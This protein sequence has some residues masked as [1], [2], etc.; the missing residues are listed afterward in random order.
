MHSL[1]APVKWIPLWSSLAFLLRSPRLLGWSLLLM[2]FTFGLTW[3][4]YLLATDFIDDR[5]IS[6]FDQIPAATG[7]WDTI[8]HYG[9]LGLKW[10]F[11]VTSRIAA[12][13]FAFLVAYTL[14][15]PGY[16]FLSAS[17][18]RKQAGQA[19]EEDV[20]TMKGVLVDIWEGLK[21]GIFGLVVTALAL[22]ANFVP[23]IGQAVVLLLYTFYSALMF[24]DYPSSRRRWSLGRKIGWLSRYRG[25]AFRLGVLPAVVSL[26]PL[27]N[28]FLMAFL[29]PLFTVHATLNFAAMDAA[30]K[31]AAGEGGSE[32]TP[33]Q[34]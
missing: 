30:E 28:I 7:F 9:W 26:I 22:M 23:L 32:V 15:A 8:R 2:L 25:Q 18:E 4:V 24:V 16:A 34:P 29:F 3:G 17:T 14:S 1:Q 10:A 19:Y 11:F 27:L 6:F 12:F 5:T 20:L 33:I 21:I 31:E 13:Y